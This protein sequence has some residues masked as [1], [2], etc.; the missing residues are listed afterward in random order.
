[1]VA[2]FK[3]KYLSK[4]NKPY[5]V[6]EIGINHNGK[7]GLALEMI[8][9]SKMVGFDAVKFQ[10]REAKDL[11]NFNYKIK[12]GTGYLSKNKNDIP[13][14]SVK[15][16]NW[17]YPDERLELKQTD[18]IKIK[19]LCKK[20]KI[21]LIVTPWDEKSVDFLCKLGV[22]AL[23]IASIDANNYH[24]CE[25][26]AKKKKP[27]IISSGMCTY[28][29][30]IKTQKFF[31]KYKTPH[32]F[33]HCTSSYPSKETDKNL[34]CIPKLK[35]ILKTDIGFSGHGTNM[36][37]SAGA[38][39]LGANVIEKHSTLSKKMAGPDHAASLEFNELH[40]LINLCTK[41]AQCLGTD[42]KKFL[43]SEKVLH[44]ILSR[45]LVARKDILKNKKLKYDDVK[46]VLIHN[47]NLGFKGNELYKII[48]KKLKRNVK[49]GH[50]FSRNNFYR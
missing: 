21:D 42:K 25:Y 36:S 31:I 37:G 13:K 44:S 46:P 16:G 18:Y 3:I 14:K 22:K 17:A 41:I 39:S 2:N 9:K 11:L 38:V 4:A 33:L 29:E 6:S 15:F 26:I 20:L 28:S 7:L 43:K 35:K 10:K 47:Q 27:T 5:F 12:K 50:I 24:F 48:N 32:M 40:N 23:K 34:L 30:L 19:K 45:R 49:R 1:V 8:K